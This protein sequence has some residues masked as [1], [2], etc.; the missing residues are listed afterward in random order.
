M[1]ILQQINLLFSK[2][3]YKRPP[4]LRVKE[5]TFVKLQRDGKRAVTLWVKYLLTLPYI[6]IY[7]TDYAGSRDYVQTPHFL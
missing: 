5:C 6:P 3:Q 7:M 4:K 1:Y 2:S